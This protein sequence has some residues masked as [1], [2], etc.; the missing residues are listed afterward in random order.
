[1]L[2]QTVCC[3]VFVWLLPASAAQSCTETPSVKNSI[4]VA[5]EVEGQVLETYFCITGYHLQGKNS[6]VCNGSEQWAASTAQCHLGHCPDPVLENG[7]FS[8]SGP[9]DVGDTVTFTCSDHYVLKGSAWSRCLEDHGWA[10]PIPTCRSRNCGPPEKPAHGYF[11]GAN[12][13]SGSTVRYYCEKR[14]SLRF[15]VGRADRRQ[16]ADGEWDSAPPACE[17]I[18]PTG[19][20]EAF[21]AFQQS[22]DLCGATENFMKRVKENGLTMEELKY[23]LE[24]KKAEL[25]AKM[26]AE[27]HSGEDW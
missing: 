23:S 7:E 14:A 18:P 19:L 3:L 8:S 20:E 11:K 9:V 24:V 26:S 15:P 5:E 17:R 16:C 21:L 6:F 27:Q 4:S 25:M 13:T 22:E 12:F 1:M 2:C 10:P